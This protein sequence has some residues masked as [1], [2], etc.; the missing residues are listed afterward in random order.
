MSWQPIETA[1]RDDTEFLGGRFVQG[2]E[3]SYRVVYYFIDDR[4]PDFP[5]VVSDGDGAHHKDFLTHWMPLPP[6]PA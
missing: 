4:D 3:P 6:P 1:P 5:W 2:E